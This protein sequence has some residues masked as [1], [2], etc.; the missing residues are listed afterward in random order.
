LGG[1]N[2]KKHYQ[3]KTLRL[4]LLVTHIEKAGVLDGN[5]DVPETVCEEL[6]MEE[7]HRK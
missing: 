7:Q 3:L 4:K 5:K 6:Y 1:L 2:G